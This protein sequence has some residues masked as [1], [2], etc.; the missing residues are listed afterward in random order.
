M[1]CKRDVNAL[2]FSSYGILTRFTDMEGMKYY[3]V[4]LYERTAE[5]RNLLRMAEVHL[6]AAGNFL[7]EES[8]LYYNEHEHAAVCARAITLYFGATPCRFARIIGAINKDRPRAPPPPRQT[9]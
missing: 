1:L 6:R 2:D 4:V 9:L 7:G 5:R 3:V 8:R